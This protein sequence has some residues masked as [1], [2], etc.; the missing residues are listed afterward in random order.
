VQI[1]FIEC[2]IDRA[3][4]VSILEVYEQYPGAL[5]RILGKDRNDVEYTELWSGASSYSMEQDAVMRAL[6]I[7]VAPQ[8]MRMDRFRL[9]YQSIARSCFPFLNGVR[10]CG[11]IQPPAKGR[12]F[13]LT[14]H[15]FT[16]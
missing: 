15:K 2:L 4:Y 3:V 16:V 12:M 11:S 14:V 5:V 8:K 13:L 7:K 9:E 1:E 6:V 10:V